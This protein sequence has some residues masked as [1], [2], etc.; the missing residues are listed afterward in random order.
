MKRFSY[1]LYALTFTTL[2]ATHFSCYAQDTDTLKLTKN[3]SDIKTETNSIKADSNNK[4]ENKVD[5]KIDNKVDNKVDNKGEEKADKNTEKNGDNKP[6]ILDDKSVEDALNISETDLWSR[7]RGGFAIPNLDNR[8]VTQQTTW[9]S[10]RTDYLQRIMQRGSRYLFHVVEALDKRGMPT[11]L[12]LLPFIESAFNPQAISTA[13]ASGMWQFMPATG[14]DFN[15]RQNIF[16]DDRRGVLDSTEAALD[17][18]QRL[19]GIFGDWQLALAAY[20]WGEGSVQRAIKKQQARG[21]P[22]DFDSLSSLMPAETKNYFP[23]LQAVKNIIGHPELFNIALPRLDNIPYFTSVKKDKDIDVKVAA[24]LADIPLSEFK[25]LNP[26]FNRPVITGGNNTS[27]LLPIENAN[28]FEANFLTWKGPLSSWTT[29]NI[30]KTEKVESLA[31]RLGYDV[32]M[33]RDV[34]A[35]PPKMLVK[36]GSTLLIPKTAKSPE[37]NISSVL[38]EQA[39]L[40]IEKPSVATRKLQIKVGRKE[41]LA[42]IAKRYKLSV[43]EIKS[44]NKL[45]K[46]QVAAGQKLVLHVAVKTKSSSRIASRPTHG[47]SRQLAVKKVGKKIK[48]RRV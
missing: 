45:H 4:A 10:A 12:A 30:Q 22:I 7:I 25:A 3:L 23:K 27:I 47:K 32:D 48:G 26:Q 13:K 6:F 29:L 18:L 37:E 38:A 33:V 44:W 5:N 8:L 17:Y 34:N 42:S 28:L 15:L 21:L 46:D 20:N 39:Q 11:D 35:I 19:Y 2:T 9:Y 40:T 31:S 43:A 41:S 36:A 24:Q 1:C 16:K 14:R